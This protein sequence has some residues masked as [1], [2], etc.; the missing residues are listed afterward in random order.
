MILLSFASRKTPVQRSPLSTA[1]HT[2]PVYSLE[3][4]GT[5]NAHNLIS[6]STDGRVCAWSLDMLAEPQEVLDLT[7]K[8]SRQVALPEA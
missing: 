4:V 7:W 1:A 2:H 8:Q 5:Q 6:A 3:V